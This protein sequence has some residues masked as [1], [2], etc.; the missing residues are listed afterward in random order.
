VCLDV[1]EFRG[2]STLSVQVK[3]IRLSGEYNDRVFGEAVA[4]D[5]FVSGYGADSALLLPSREDVAA[6]Y[7]KILAAPVSAKRAEYL[8][9]DTIG[10]AKTRVSL[11]I[12]CELGLVIFDGVNYVVAPERKKTELSNSS[13][14][15]ALKGGE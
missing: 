6:V 2:N 1:N 12:L 14:Y 3:A 11:K 8:F 9:L 5:D 7:K 13:T 15:T 4:F 10:Y